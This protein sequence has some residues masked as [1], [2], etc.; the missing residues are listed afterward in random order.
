[1]CGEEGPGWRKRIPHFSFRGVM[2]RHRVRAEGEKGFKGK[3]PQVSF[4]WASDSGV[5]SWNQVTF[6]GDMPIRRL[7][8]MAWI[9]PNFTSAGSARGWSSR[10]S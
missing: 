8:I 4:P 5:T 1:M 9:G 7:S 10:I 6:G 2:R 3:K